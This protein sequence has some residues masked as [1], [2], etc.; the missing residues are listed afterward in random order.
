VIADGVAQDIVADANTGGTGRS[1]TINLDHSV[2]TAEA[3][4][5]GA[6]NSASVT[7]VGTNSNLTTVPTDIF[8]CAPGCGMEPDFHQKT[9]SPTINAGV[10]DSL[11]GT[12]DFD[13]NVRPQGAAMDIGA[14]EMVVPPPPGGGG[15]PP[16]TTP[17]GTTPP[18]N[19]GTKKK[20]KKRKKHR[21]AE[22]KK[23][24]CKKRRK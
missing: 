10:T 16:G 18:P 4:P 22:A 5:S 23:K 7:P 2:Y 21:A 20:C 17:P 14:Y 9:G 11:T 15:T 8:L 13:G 1:V 24:K 12:T 19:N 3:H 6:G